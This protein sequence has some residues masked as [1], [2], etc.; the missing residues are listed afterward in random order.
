VEIGELDRPNDMNV[1]MH[2]LA[3]SARS[4]SV[5]CEFCRRPWFGLVAYCPYCGRMSS[6]FTTMNQ[7]PDGHFQ[8]DV[9]LAN[10]QA[11]LGMPAGQLQ[12]QASTDLPVEANRPAPSQFNKIKSA[13]PLLLKTAAA[14]ITVLLLFWMVVKLPAPKTNERATPQLPIS[15]SGIASPNQ[16]PPTSAAQQPSIP[17]RT[18]TPVPPN[19]TT[20][21]S[22]AH[23][24]AGLCKSQ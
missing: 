8:S 1:R 7:Q 24:T 5:L 23:E 4:E 9:A 10:G 22:L 21:C 6:C 14:G 15:T 18:D 2:Q 12:R 17:L 20:L 16:R 11:S 13:L 19:R 3:Q